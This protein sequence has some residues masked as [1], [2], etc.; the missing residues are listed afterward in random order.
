MVG[1]NLYHRYHT[2]AVLDDQLDRVWNKEI[3]RFFEYSSCGILLVTPWRFDMN[4]DEEDPIYVD[5]KFVDGIEPEWETDQM[6]WRF[7]KL[8]QETV[9]TPGQSVNA[10]IPEL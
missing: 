3:P 6:L 2:I 4:K 5:A 8:L 7:Q 1:S 9:L 10:I